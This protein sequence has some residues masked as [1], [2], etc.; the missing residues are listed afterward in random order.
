MQK[1]CDNTS[2]ITGVVWNKGKQKWVAQI[3]YKN[4]MRYLGGFINKDDAIY[5]RLQAEQK[6]FGEFAPQKHLYE[7][8]N[9]N[10]IQNDFDKESEK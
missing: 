4:K 1:R 7:Q 5:A 9:I 10:T 8:Y 2:G 3:Q 6:Y